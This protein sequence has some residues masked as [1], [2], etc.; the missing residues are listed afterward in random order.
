MDSPGIVLIAVLAVGIFFVLLPWMGHIFARY[1]AP[2]AVRCPE[3]GTKAWVEVDALH[4]A[5][6]AACGAPRLR[7][8]ECSLWADR[9]ACAVSCLR[10]REAR[11]A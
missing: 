8:R 9:G 5:L 4:A 3:T 2:R 11:S 7:A 6:T 1:R 10:P